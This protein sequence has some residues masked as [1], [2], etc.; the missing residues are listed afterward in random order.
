MSL[1]LGDSLSFT[2]RSVQTRLPIQR[3]AE[4]PQ[5]SQDQAVEDEK[6]ARQVSAEKGGKKPA[7]C[8]AFNF[9]FQSVYKDP[10]LF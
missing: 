3:G 6:L 5:N 8:H 9:C 1:R 7:T 4:E 10:R 2:P